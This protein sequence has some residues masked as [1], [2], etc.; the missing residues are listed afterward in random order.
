MP[1]QAKV[2]RIVVAS[3]GDVQAERDLVPT[4]V[5]EV[6]RGVAGERDIVLKVT[7]WEKDAYPGFHAG[8]PQALIDGILRIPEC[9][10][11]IG[12]FWTRFGTPV[13]DAKSGTEHE[14]RLAYEAWK[15]AGR[16]Q[17][18]FYFNEK[19]Y[20]PKSKE[21]TDQWGLVLDFK[22]NFP[23]E[24]L[25]WP[26]KG[27]LQFQRLLRDHLEA[28]LRKE[29]PLGATLASPPPA[30][31]ALH[32][33]PAPPGDFTGRE[34][35]IKEILGGIEK[36]TVISGLQGMGGVGKTALALVL[37]EQLSER[38]PDGQFYLDLKGTSAQPLT[39]A[40]AMAHVI[41]AYNPEAK[42]P[43]DEAQLS[44]LYHSALHEK[45]AILLM[46]NARDAAQVMPLLPPAEC[47]LLVT[48]RWH[49]VV[50]GLFAKN[51]DTLPPQ[52]ARELLLAIACGT[53]A[54]AALGACP[55]V[56]R[57][58]RGAPALAERRYS[59][60]DAGLKPASTAD[61]RMRAIIAHADEI[62][63][64][65]GYLP[66][67]LRATG[68]ALA[69]AVDLAPAEYAKRL[70]EARKRLELVEASL[71]LSYELLPSELQARFA[72]LA[73]F[74]ETLDRGAAAAVW[75]IEP[76][77][78][79][80]AL[81][82]LLKY[83][84]LEYDAAKARYWLHDL[85]RDFASA[86]LASA[87]REKAERRH[88]AHYVQVARVAD[89]LYLKGGEN[90]A[91]G[92][93]LFDA[94]WANIQAG[95]AWAAA[96]SEGD[97]EAAKACNRYPSDARYCLVLRQH[98]HE[99][100]RWLEAG[101][102][103][104]RRLK[105]RAAEGVHLGNLGI[106]YA[107]LG[108]THRAVEFFE[109]ALE[110]DR[111]VGDKHGEATALGNL[112]LAHAGLGETRRSIEFY[113]KQLVITREIDDRRGEGNALGNLGNAYLALGETRRAIEFYEKCLVIHREIGDRRGE[114][115]ALGNLGNAYADL[116][117]TRRA[118]EFYEK[119][120]V[121]TREIGDRRG[122][123][124]ALGNLGNAY[125]DLGETRRAIGYHEKALEIDRE[126]GD[127]RGEGQDL[128]NL[129]LAY[130]DL[131]ETRRAIESFEQS[132]GVAREIGDRRG[133][134]AA[135]LNMSLALDELGDRAQ[136]IAHAQAAFKVFEQIEDPNTEKVRRQ[137]AEWGRD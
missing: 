132:L 87:E 121:I 72:A 92:L 83:S 14:Y 24:G 110:I 69:E 29:F 55:D 76:D 56:G 89:E 30:A 112:G 41:R 84:L 25:W 62:A 103:A 115:N 28:Y 86:R 17:I 100:I 70:G 57:D 15:K 5:E 37:A 94:E 102:A 52:D 107:E 46:D 33:L 99:Q 104:A 95:Q 75:A 13:A 81:S 38:Y 8:G 90:L 22:K 97:K 134:G 1:E 6:N 108:E 51:L 111:E 63:K 119:Q 130:A 98:P 16:P 40:Q 3:P 4:V 114:G 12:I 53:R 39:P 129:G 133:E 125:A 82:S 19:P 68:S 32:Q 78:A 64:L 18:F 131:G 43:E 118:I 126:I 71:G 79:Q 135:L 65:C 34:T 101:L 123:G 10:I 9:D 48:S 49:F 58:R 116:G 45:C 50:A 36:G 74:P 85:V 27:K 54:V 47:L 109:K 106:C 61:P 21:E 113:E 120:L 127:R 66:L 105:I 91:R 128:G 31:P 73:V 42:L 59:K 137:L 136:A 7:R 67:A 122:E 2:L 88:A 80:D 77:A 124:N 23:K 93:A 11:F 60:D 44:P 26:Y 20:A 96:H 117:E 35:E